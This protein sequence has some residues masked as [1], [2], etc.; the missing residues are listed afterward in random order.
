M[1]K[2]D[3]EKDSMLEASEVAE[4][5]LIDFAHNMKGDPKRFI[6][7]W[8]KFFEKLPDSTK[9]LIFSDI[10]R[11]LFEHSNVALALE[12]WRHTLEYYTKLGDDK[13]GEAN[14]YANIGYTYIKL[15]Q[16]REG[17]KSLE[18]ALDVS[19]DIKHDIRAKSRWYVNLGAAYF[20]LA[21]YRKGIESQERALEIKT[22]LGDKGGEANCYANIGICYSNLGQYQKGIEYQEKALVIRREVSDKGGESDCYANIGIIYYDLGQYQKGIEYQEKAL[23]LAKDIDDKQRES[24]CYM[25]IGLNH[26]NLGQYPDAIKYLNKALEMKEEL[27][28]RH[29]LSYCYVNLGIIYGSLGHYSDAIQFQEKALSVFGERDAKQGELNCYANIGYAYYNL[30]QY[31]DAKKYLDEG[32]KIAKDIGD[33]SGLTRVYRIFALIYQRNNPDRAY[34]YLQES[35]NLSESMSAMLVKEVD[36]IEFQSLH[37]NA[38]ALI[39][40]ICLKLQKEDEERERLAYQYVE[41]SKSRALIDMMSASNSVLPTAQMTEELR[42]LIEEENKRISRLRQI[43]TQHI[44]NEKVTV[45]PGEVDRLRQELSEIYYQIEKYDKQYVSLRKATPIPLSEVQEKL[46]SGRNAVIVEYFITQEKTFI[47]VVSQKELHVKEVEVTRDK[48]IVYFRNY[49]R[50]VVEYPEYGD[51]GDFSLQE[52]SRYLVEPISQY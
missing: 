2:N 25:R 10:G 3:I 34:E 47:F 31:P 40:P 28:D 39:V 5:V 27:G 45:E 36:K 43:Q 44:R 19:R 6:A 9:V 32:L 15:G 46:A 11:I 52:L 49:Q 1:E 17:V 33:I 7:T 35:I 24:S 29:S 20:Q 12:S 13:G 26:N 42:S 50:E 48:L 21:E 8:E 4:S 18:K 37:S 16:Y 38:Y 41:Q 30:G 22:R 23:K 51:I 14:C